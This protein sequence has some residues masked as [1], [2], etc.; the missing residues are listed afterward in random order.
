[1]SQDSNNKKNIDK[2]L[3][4]MIISAVVLL[5][6]FGYTMY[7]GSVN[8]KGS[9]YYIGIIFL[10]VLLFLS[11]VI[12]IKQDKIRAYFNKNKKIMLLMLK[13]KKVEQKL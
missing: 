12:K 2:N 3:K 8:I 1:M 5:V 13:L 7:K 11:F 4:L 6:L 10:F 9:S